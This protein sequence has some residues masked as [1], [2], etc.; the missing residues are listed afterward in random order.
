MNHRDYLVD[1]VDEN[2]SVVGSKRRDEIDKSKDRYHGV[3]VQLLTPNREVVL[4]RIPQRTDLPNRY[5]HLWGTTAAAI[6]RQSETAE[7]AA[8]RALFRELYMAGA[9]VNLLGEG[10]IKLPDEREVYMSAFYS[11]AK[12]PSRFSNLD[13]EELRTISP[14]RL[15]EEMGIDPEQF[16]PTLLAFWDK[17]AD[18]LPLS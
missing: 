16:A 18:N 4:G 8:K 15:V 5:T 2:G 1:L 13:I 9:E 6:R 3:Y 12:R 17:Y 7:E 10:L 11:L 14:S